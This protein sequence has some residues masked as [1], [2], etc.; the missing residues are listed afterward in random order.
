MDRKPL[1]I[2]PDEAVGRGG[3][4]SGAAEVGGVLQEPAGRVYSQLV[5]PAS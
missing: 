1:R 4:D 2:E 5:I 3:L